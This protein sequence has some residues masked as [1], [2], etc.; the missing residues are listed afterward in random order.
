[1]NHAGLVSRAERWLRNTAVVPSSYGTGSCYRTRCAVVLA[2][3]VTSQWE[4]PDAIGWCES[5]KVSVLVEC[6]TSRSD[7]IA[8][9]KKP[10]RRHPHT[11][12]GMY[13]YYFVP[14]GVLRT[15]DLPPLWGL[16]ETRGRSVDVV[17]LPEE[18]PEFN[19]THEMQML[20]SAL[21]RV[22][23]GKVTK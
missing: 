18:H 20:W 7:F 13:R 16:L 19:R 6:K 15:G 8:D 10:F 11:G 17:R 23:S 14:P 2:G 22:Q 1:M 21:R 3:L 5:G 4:V 12:M 9:A